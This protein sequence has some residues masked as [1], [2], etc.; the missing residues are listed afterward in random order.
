MPQ[1]A[2][3]QVLIVQSGRVLLGQ[4][5]TGWAEGKYTGFIGEVN[6][7]ETTAAAAV[8]IVREQSGLLL[9]EEKLKR[10]AV[11]QFIETKEGH[12]DPT[13]AGAIETSLVERAQPP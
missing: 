4:H 13:S 2:I 10:R 9:Q 3:A 6:Y 11:I 8:R 7:G 1:L 5:R 12:P